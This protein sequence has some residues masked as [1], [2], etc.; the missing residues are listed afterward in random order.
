[1]K[2]QKLQA[3]LDGYDEG[4]DITPD[5]FIAELHNME[6]QFILQ[7]LCIV[8]STILPSMESTDINVLVKWELFFDKRKKA[9]LLFMSEK[10]TN[11]LKLAERFIASSETVAYTL[12][13]INSI[14]VRGSKPLYN[15]LYI[16]ERVD[17][18]MTKKAVELAAR[19]I[20]KLAMSGQLKE[21]DL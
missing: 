11:L 5:D 10:N 4:A 2:K 7:S 8:L 15:Y 21:N 16:L 12:D 13:H 18:K 19:D 20:E 9:I 3:I 17:F 1:M 14:M 6:L